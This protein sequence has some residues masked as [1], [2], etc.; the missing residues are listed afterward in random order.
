MYNSDIIIGTE[1]WLRAEMGNT[2]IFRADFTTFRR[3][4]HARGEGL[5]IRVKNYI[6]CSELRVDDEFEIITMEVKGSDPKCT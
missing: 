1:L 4:R 5:F 6:A 2:E 3:D